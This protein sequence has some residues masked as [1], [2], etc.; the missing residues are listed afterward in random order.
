MEPLKV[1]QLL[2]NRGDGISIQLAAAKSFLEKNS[3]QALLKRV[4]TTISEIPEAAHFDNSFIQLSSHKSP[5]HFLT[6]KGLFFITENR[7]LI[8]DCTAGHYQMPWGYDSPIIVPLIQEAIQ[9]GITW[10]C[11][12]DIPG[13]A[14]KALARE[15]VALAN[16]FS[17]FEDSQMTQL[18]NDPDTL[19]RAIVSTCTGTV[20]CAAAFRMAYVYHRKHKQDVGVPVFITFTNNYHGTDTFAQRMRGMWEEMFDNRGVIFEQIEPNN[21]N[22]LNRVFEK[23]GRQVA[24][25]FF[26]PV[27]MNNEAL[28]LQPELV[29]KMREKTQEVDA[30]LVA[31]EIQSCFFVPECMMF[32]QY[33]IEPDA[34][35]VGKGMTAGFHGQSATIFKSKYD[36][37]EQFDAL[38]TNGN[39]P[40]ACLAGLACIQAIK[41]N[42]QHLTAMQQ[43]YFDNLKRIA[44]DFPA[45]I[46]ASMG[47][48]LLSGLKFHDREKAIEARTQLLNQ[49]LWVRVHAYKEN[50]RT[51]LMKFALVVNEEVITFFFEKVRAVLQGMR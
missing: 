28:H 48:G 38:S 8:L 12:S 5:D 26:E 41:Q 7:Q 23:W 9:Q 25:F 43:L 34:V 13:A 20:A 46:E 11:H 45:L 22:E 2:G 40:L 29:K 37:L 49:G 16:G 18:E 44:A 31:D 6:G 33:G 10:D 36:L 27:M 39:A 30:M 32:R 3:Q 42:K 50:H 35:I 24:C 51:L 4:G 47:H 17:S 14:V 15:L 19:N 1:T 21:L